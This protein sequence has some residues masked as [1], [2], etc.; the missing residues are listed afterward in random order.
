MKTVIVKE[1]FRSI[2]NPSDN[3]W[4]DTG[5][6]LE[7]DFST[8]YR[9]SRV[10]KTEAKYDS[11][12]YDPTLWKDQKFINF[13]G[14]IDTQ[15]GFGNVSYHLLKESVGELK[16][17]S[18]G[19]TYGVRDQ[20]VFVCQNTPLNQAGVMI[21]HDQPREEWLYSPFNKNIA[22]V[23]WETTL[24]PKSWLAKINNFDGLLVPCK[25]NIIDFRNSGVTVPI[26]LIHWGFDP[27]RFYPLDRPQRDIFT[28]GHM[29]SL[30]IRKGTDLLVE[31]FQE[32]FPREKD[33]R[34]ICKTSN[35]TYPFNVKDKRIEVLL[36]PYTPE[37][38][39]NI[40]F[41]QIDCFVFPTR[42]EGFGLTSLEALATGVPVIVTNWAGPTEFMTPEVGWAIDYKMVPAKQFTENVYKEECGNWSEPNKEHLIELMRYA[43]NHREEVKEKGKAAARYALE[44]WT[45]SKKIKM[46]HYALNKFL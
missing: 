14:D 11:I 42:G 3:K 4:Y 26:E 35:N 21:W 12:P 30:S 6:D 33:V 45:W 20:S 44:N 41:K 9:L 39:L 34:L 15:S 13:C 2:L 5:I 18:M 43:Y 17:A 19:K 22:I 38:L 24:I 36:T 28:F 29:G 25:Q 46:F 27:N 1:K 7:L 23:P 16:I 8:A 31:A 40:F 37:E 32:A 10:A